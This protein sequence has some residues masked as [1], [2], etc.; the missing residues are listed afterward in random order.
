[1][2]AELGRDALHV[3]L[4]GERADPQL[5]GDL[6]HG[7][8]GS[9]SSQDLGLTGRETP[10]RQLGHDRGLSARSKLV[11]RDGEL[12]G[13]IT[14]SPEAARRTTF[15]ASAARVLDK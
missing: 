13:D 14:I 7:L 1:V 5:V 4:D 9:Q 10:E 15:K 3:A 12:V 2:H 11:E 8:A 6:A